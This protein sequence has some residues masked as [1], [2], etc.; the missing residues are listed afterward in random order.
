[1]HQGIVSVAPAG[2]VLRPVWSVG[3]VLEGHAVQ[4]GLLGLGVC[5]FVMVRLQ[6]LYIGKHHVY[7]HWRRI[8]VCSFGKGFYSPLE[9]IGALLGL[10]Q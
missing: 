1:M 2:F 3:R 5:L 8:G 10:F 4:L 9:L 6:G 7:L